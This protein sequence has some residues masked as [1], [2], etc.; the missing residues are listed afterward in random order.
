MLAVA[1]LLMALP[2]L[3][4]VLPSILRAG[5]VV[6][7]PLRG[8][9]P[10]LYEGDVTTHD[11]VHV[12][13]AYELDVSWAHIGVPHEHDELKAVLGD[14]R[15]A[16][17]LA[18]LRHELIGVT[19][20]VLGVVPQPRILSVGEVAPC[21]VHH[22][23]LGLDGQGVDLAPLVGFLQQE[24]DEVHVVHLRG[25]LQRQVG[26]VVSEG[27]KCGCV[28]VL[29]VHVAEEW[30]YVLVPA[31]TVVTVLLCV[32]FTSLHTAFLFGKQGI[33]DALQAVFGGRLGGVWPSFALCSICPNMMRAACSALALSASFVV[34][35]L[36]FP[37]INTR[38]CQYWLASQR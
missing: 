28:D 29:H 11:V 9:V 20:A 22:P 38:N 23:Q 26:Q 6:A 5:H 17:C 14:A 35:W 37:S 8:A 32:Q 1:L 15:L 3:L 27:F 36:C 18:P 13:V 34:L 2:H 19:H 16:V 30:A 7:V 31:V 12:P 24:H 21:L 4:V 33:G 10:E 25:R